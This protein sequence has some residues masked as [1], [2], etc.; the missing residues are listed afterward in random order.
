MNEGQIL[1]TFFY[2]LV[3]AVVFGGSLVVSI[4]SA[5][6]A[7]SGKSPRRG[8]WLAAGVFAAII[9]IALAFVIVHLWNAAGE[10]ILLS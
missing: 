9:A 2:I 4:V 1:T 10:A 3:L 5:I 6:K 8:R 7:F